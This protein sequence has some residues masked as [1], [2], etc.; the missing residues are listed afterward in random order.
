MGSGVKLG[1]GHELGG[2]DKNINCRDQAIL[3]LPEIEKLCSAAHHAGVPADTKR[4]ADC[5]GQRK[6][7]KI[8]LLCKPRFPRK[9][10]SF[11]RARFVVDSIFAQEIPWTPI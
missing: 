6:S 9:G 1:S 11:F 7:G 5:E 3:N 4:D 8:I 2:R 10:K